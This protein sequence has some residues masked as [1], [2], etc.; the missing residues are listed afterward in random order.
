MSMGCLW[1]AFQPAYLVASP[2]ETRPPL[3]ERTKSILI[4]RSVT[5]RRGGCYLLRMLGG[6]RDEDGS[7]ADVL[8]RGRGLDKRV[9]PSTV[10]V[11]FLLLHVLNPEPAVLRVRE[12]KKKS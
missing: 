12:V 6:S 8:C 9:T 3:R 5:K 11:F 7:E 10:G 2:V 4:F 1:I